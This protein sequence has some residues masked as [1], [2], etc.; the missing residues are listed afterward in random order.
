MT[1]ENKQAH[2]CGRDRMC[3]G[4]PE[5]E[6]HH[7]AFDQEADEDEHECR[8]DQRVRPLMGQGVVQLGQADAPRPGE[9]KAQPGQRE[10]GAQAVDDAEVDAAL[11]SRLVLDDDRRQPVGGRAH[12]LE[13]HEEV[14]EVAGE[15]EADH[16]RQEQQHETVVV[17]FDGVEIANAVEEGDRHQAARQQ[18]RYRRPEDPRRT[19]SRRCSHGAETIRQPRSRCDHPLTWPGDSPA[20]PSGR[21]PSA[22]AIR[23]TARRG[24]LR[25]ATSKTQAMTMGSATAIGASMA[26]PLSKL[27]ASGTGCAASPGSRSARSGSIVLLRLWIWIAMASSM[28]VTVAETTMSVSAMAWTRGIDDVQGGLRGWLT[29]ERRRGTPLV[30]DGEQEHVGP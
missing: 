10:V 4:Q 2:G 5:V 25:P 22:M 18:A 17:R 14:E 12:E 23:S 19:R 16:A 21:A 11:E 27:A 13:E 26:A 3:V 1:P 30:A 29:E 28:E 7:G 9:Q 6:R 24:S 8:H 15:G 20:G